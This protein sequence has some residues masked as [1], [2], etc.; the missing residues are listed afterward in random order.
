MTAILEN[1]WVRF[2][3]SYG[4]I[5]TNDNMYDETIQRAI[6]KHGIDPIRL[7]AQF[8]DSL[9]ENFRSAAPRSE[10]L[11][12]TAGDGKT[13]H[14]REVWTA[15]G[16]SPT[17]WNRGKKVNI[18]PL[19]GRELVIVKDL[20]ELREESGDLLTKMAADIADASSPRRYLIAANH[21]QLLEK[22]KEAPQSP[23]VEAMSRAI[24][25]MLVAGENPNPNLHLNL[26]DLSRA[27]AAGRA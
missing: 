14:A 22:L 3:R 2:F 9:L 10:V 15:L 5:P 19:G 11:T 6:S 23:A 18:L 7:P 16:G 12:G 26:R 20:S 24:E 17:E 8:L 4:P 25:E 27:P 1:K 21:G 13:Y